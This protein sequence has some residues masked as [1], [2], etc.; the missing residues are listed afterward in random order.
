MHLSNVAGTAPWS[1]DELR[2]A[3]GELLDEPAPAIGDHDDLLCLGLDSIAVMRL[4]ARWRGAGL[5]IGFGDLIERRT[6]AQW[7]ELL[8][9]AESVSPEDSP[10]APARDDTT[11][12]FELATMQHAYWVGRADGQELGGVGSHFYCE[13]GGRSVE[14]ERLEEAVREMVR[15]H[16]MLRCRFADDGRQQVLAD[17]PWPGLRVRDLTG[18]GAEAAEAGLREAREALSHRRLAVDRGEVFDVRLTRLPDGTSRV[19]F[20]IE[21]MVSDAHSFQNLLSDLAACYANPGQSLEPLGYTFRRYLAERGE[22]G[23]RARERA[24]EYWRKRVPDLPPPPALPVRPLPRAG[25]R[26]MTRRFHW[27]PPCQRDLLTARAREHGLTLSA[28][29][30]TAFAEVLAVWSGQSELLLNLPVYDREPVHPDVPRLVGDFTNLV[31]LGVEVPGGLSFAEQVR[32]V[33][34]RLHADAS[35]TAYSGIEVLR[36]LARLH[37]D[38]AHLAPVVFTTAMSLGELF[39]DAVRR[40]FGDPVWTMSQTPQVWLDHQVTERDGGLYVNWD[41]V[42]DLFADGVLDAMFDA[43]RGLLAW[44]AEAE[45]TE[46][47]PG[48]LPAGHLEVRAAVNSTGSE[49]PDGLLHSGFFEWAA[50][51]SSRVAVVWGDSGRASFGALGDWALRIAGALTA[52]GVR[53]GDVVGVSVARGAGQVAGVLGV[54]AAGAAYV[55]VGVEQPPAR[56]ERIYRS[57]GVRVVLGDGSAVEAPDWI[58]VV[59]VNGAVNSAPLERPVGVGPDDLAYVIYT[60]GST[61]VPKGVEV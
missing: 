8:A 4:A 61:G 24:R 12:P 16:A 31:L 39:D 14:A 57:A 59:N 33:Q 49:V 5:E 23:T 26:Q 36:D 6:L 13:F 45:W 50:R 10:T 20:Q 60:S 38:R 15:R 19:H 56:R 28:V 7:H 21:M 42:D 11:E 34:A 1:R 48:L 52:R 54:L 29:F 58:D 43:Y 35:N 55:P 46:G 41:A 47:I 3:I 18:A 37:P 32:R 40:H 53:P 17:S 2:T 30:L 27:L 44:L 22:H 25:G 9:T 51:D